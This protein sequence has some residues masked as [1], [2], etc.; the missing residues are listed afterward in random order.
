MSRADDLA[1]MQLLL[2]Q[3]RGPAG[4]SLGLLLVAL[5]LLG[6]GSGRTL[7]ETALLLASVLA[8][9]VQ[10]G[11]AWRVRR[12]AD[13]LQLLRDQQL[14]GQAAARRADQLLQAAGL[15]RAPPPQPL[16]SWAS[17]WAGMRS[18]LL[19]QCVAAALQLLVL[20]L[21]LCWP[22]L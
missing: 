20:L 19:G 21:A 22:D 5:L 10:A 16:R 2:R 3:G 4:L 13:L 14:D 11:Y 15:R 7:L 8:G 1:A 18:L 9:L 12:D 17:R 6:S